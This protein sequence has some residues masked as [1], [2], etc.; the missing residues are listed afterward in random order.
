MK[1]PEDE[2]SN[3]IPQLKKKKKGKR[4]RKEKEGKE[5]D[6]NIYACATHYF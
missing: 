4:K 3:T 2:L 6:V 5:S 1:G